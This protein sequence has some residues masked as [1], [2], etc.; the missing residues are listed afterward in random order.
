MV[1]G[2]AIFSPNYLLA[3]AQ[4]GHMRSTIPMRFRSDL[5]ISALGHAAVIEVLGRILREKADATT[6]PTVVIRGDRQA[7]YEKVALA[8][9][10]AQSL[11]VA[12]LSL[13]VDRSG[14][15]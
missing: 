9:G 8:M 11:G 1:S 15:R 2:S 13:V 12:N 4:P 5:L 10:I 7:P 3:S 14:T 6:K